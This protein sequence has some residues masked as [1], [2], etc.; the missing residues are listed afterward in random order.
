MESAF[1]IGLTNDGD[2][3]GRKCVDNSKCCK[4]HLH[5]K[6]YTEDQLKN[7]EQCKGCK[8]YH[9]FGGE[10]KTCDICKTRGSKNREIQKEKRVLCSKEG[11]KF[12]RSS[13]NPYCM[14]HQ[15]C[16]FVDETKELDKNVCVNYVRGCRAQLEMD[17][18]YTRCGECLRKDREK[19]KQKRNSVKVA[20]ETSC[21]KTEDTK[22]VIQE[23]TCTV[24]VQTRPMT[25][26]VGQKEGVITKTCKNCRESCKRNDVK[27]D[28]KH[29]NELDI[30]AQNKPER[31]YNKY[32]DSATK[33]NITPTGKKNETKCSYDLYIL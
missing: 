13:I 9:F 31:K 1:C 22:E 28:K 4:F 14:V 6:D 33:R 32:L 3:C 30:L 21:E 17:Y 18:K 24:C 25:E 15:M 27:R 20:L 26:F 23:K 16:L 2:A 10:S 29:R 7:M 8:K 11:C 19:D 12:K 5:I